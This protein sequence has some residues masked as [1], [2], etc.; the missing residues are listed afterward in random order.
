MRGE[1]IILKSLSGSLRRILGTGLIILLL[2]FISFRGKAQS[3]ASKY[4]IYQHSEW[5]DS[6]MKNM[7]LDEKIGQLFMVSAYSAKD[8]MNLEELTKLVQKYKVGGLI[9]FRGTPYK[10]AEMTNYLQSV[11]KIPLLVSIDG[12]WGLA[13]RLDST[14]NFGRQM[15]LGAIA[16]DSI[17]YRMG[18]EIARECK[19]M[20]I[21]INFAPVVDVNNNPLNPVINVR[22]FG[23]DKKKVSRKSLMYLRG[24]QDMHVM[25]VAK[26][27]PGHG[28][29][30][31]DS[32]LDLPVLNQNEEEL[33]TLELYPFRSMF[34][35]GIGGVMTAHLHIPAYDTVK[36]VGASVSPKVC[37]IL[38][39]DEMKYKGIAFS[40]ALNMGGVSKY[41]APGELEYRALIAGNDI[42]LCSEDVPKGIQ[43]IKEILLAGCISMEFLDERVRRILEAKKWCG[44]DSCTYIDM[45]HLT[46]DL[47]HPDALLLKQEIAEK[48]V[49]LV[50]NDLKLVP[51]HNSGAI[52]IA[53]VAMGIKIQQP[54]QEM[55]HKYS[56]ASLFNILI[57]ASDTDY[58]KLEDTLKHYDLIIISLQKLSNK[59][60]STYGLSKQAIEFIN[61]MNQ[62]KKCILV[63]FGSPYALSRFPDFKTIICSYEDDPS[64]Q[65]AAAELIFGGIT[66]KARLPVTASA[67]FPQGI[68]VVSNELLRVKYSLPEDVGMSSEL[69]S[70]IKDVVDKGIKAKAMPGCQIVIA[71]D[72]KIIYEKGFGYQQY[73]T[74]DPIGDND[75]YDLASVTKVAATTLVA[76][77]LYETGKL[78]IFEKLGTY[79]PE[80]FG[81]NKADLQIKEL[82]THQA[83][84]TEWIPFY[85]Q[86]CT[87]N[88]CPSLDLYCNE[89][90]EL[91][92]LRVAN[93]MYITRL[94]R[95]SIYK[96]IDRSPIHNRGT[97]LYSDLGFIYMQ[98]VIER[99]TGK[100]IDKLADSLYY[101]P[102]GLASTTYQ[103]LKKFFPRDIAPTELD[104]YFRYQ[105]IRGDVH[106]PAAAMLGGVAGHAGLFSNGNDLAVLMQ[107]LVEGGTYAGHKYLDSSTIHIFTSRQ[108]ETNRKG[109]GW[110][111]PEMDPSKP[112][113]TSRYASSRAYGHMGFTGTCVWVDPQY[114][115][116]YVFLSNRVYPNANVNTLSRMNIRT[117]IQ[118]IIYRSILNRDKQ[119]SKP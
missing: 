10:Q 94:Y 43:R 25:A 52:R 4:P 26:H 31:V 40:D 59:R 68:G 46:A 50:K 38:L 81:T 2:L 73:N 28:N 42:L 101:K 56:R 32:H 54:F 117:D 106:D 95:D 24:L 30:D 88:Y 66:A 82:M 41:Y 78:N 61:R 63:D 98:R 92:N 99:I 21:H 77:K 70:H 27:F 72:G 71:K 102:L 48:A 89:P 57:F 107:M 116:V 79:L 87:D 53:N 34:A 111:K 100:T 86:T 91:Y 64:F 109:L 16:D 22:S 15:P 14:I 51:I 12:E 11:S 60:T 97:C 58:T 84:L 35:N 55:V 114:N 75:I 96:I 69:L 80:L 74:L 33:D 6:L 19:R 18:K 103:P 3:A 93:N 5:V 9:F 17:V 47:N 112:T 105:L 44:L 119:V 90:N 20:G 118:D 8:K 85:K 13:M 1:E 108:Y 39:R 76:M 113:P 83:G 115:L 23:E 104:T 62:Q 67:E 110:E 65:V 45:N 29:T 7:T 36:N 37:T 49:T